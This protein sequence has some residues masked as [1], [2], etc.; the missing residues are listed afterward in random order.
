MN[1]YYHVKTR[2]KYNSLMEKMELLGYVWGSGNLPTYENNWEKH[3]EQ[4]VVEIDKS[5]K[6][7][8]FADRPYYIAYE[9]VPEEKIVEFD[10]KVK[11]LTISEYR[12]VQ[13]ALSRAMI[14]LHHEIETIENMLE[15]NLNPFAT[16]ALKASLD[17]YKEELKEIESLRL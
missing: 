12:I 1:R 17:N 14:T 9:L 5:K 13:C 2:E 3:K 6:K 11:A 7:M 8:F 4:T 16:A 15:G 10:Q